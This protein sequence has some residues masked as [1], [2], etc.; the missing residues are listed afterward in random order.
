MK[1]FLKY[2]KV[3]GMVK[4]YVYVFYDIEDVVKKLFYIGKGKL[5]C[6]FDYIKYNDDF[7]KLE[8]IN[9]LLKIGNLG[10]DILCY[11]MDEVIVKFVEVICIDF[12]GV[13][14]LINKVWG[15][16]FF[17]GWIMLDEFNYFFFK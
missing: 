7:L 5:E 14:E 15:S 3:L 10:I 9:Y 16:S 2:L 12:L 6:C 4:F 17:M 8:W 1:D 11:G 13:G